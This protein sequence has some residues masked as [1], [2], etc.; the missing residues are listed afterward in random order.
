MLRSLQILMVELP[1][2]NTVTVLRFG[3]SLIRCFI[4]ELGHGWVTS[5]TCPRSVWRESSSTTWV[6][7]RCQISPSSITASLAR[8][9]GLHPPALSFRLLCFTGT[10]HLSHPPSLICLSDR[11]PPGILL[12]VSLV[13][14]AVD[15]G[16]S[17]SARAPVLCVYIHGDASMA[18]LPTSPKAE[19]R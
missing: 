12:C 17:V 8:N 7:S 14:S 19:K 18:P 10:T 13:I 4:G 2:S 6:P 5:S 16:V 15:P 11:L 9:R 3:D 1:L